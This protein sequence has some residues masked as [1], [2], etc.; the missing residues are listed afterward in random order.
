MLK[1]LKSAFW[2]R[3][4]MPGLGRVPL[5]LLVLA[6]LGILGLGSPV[7]WWAAL[8]WEALYLAALTAN[9]RFRAVAEAESLAAA[10]KDQRSQ[11]RA[12]LGKLAFDARRRY[13]A[14]EQKCD[15]VLAAKRAAARDDILPLE[16]G[17]GLERMKAIFLKLLLAQ[18][19]IE[20][21]DL[22]RDGEAL[23]RKIASLESE[24][25]AG[26][27][28]VAVRESKKATLMALRLRREALERKS[29]TLREI[30]SDLERIEAQIDLALES[31]E[32][33]MPDRPGAYDIDLTCKLLG[34]DY[35]LEPE[36]WDRPL[37]DAS[38]KTAA[39]ARPQAL[40]K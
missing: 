21:S 13:E 7:F 27:L 36:D 3:P 16:D 30:A 39:P 28:P 12:L 20:S 14:L 29:E 6:S 24:M 4:A 38:A 23:E 18:R 32:S 25:A 1:Y 10:A 5:N 22:R 8:G 9:P 31:A 33:A 34:G 37:S 26:A 17:P 11:A 19:K 35:L 15:R 2:A 40:E